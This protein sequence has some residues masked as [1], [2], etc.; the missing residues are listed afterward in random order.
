MVYIWHIHGIYGIC[1]VY[2]YGMHMVSD[3]HICSVIVVWYVVCY[4]EY[5][6]WSAECG[7]W[8]LG[9]IPG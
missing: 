1:M 3:W 2:I 5:G 6:T 7:M 8:Y 4:V 9:Y